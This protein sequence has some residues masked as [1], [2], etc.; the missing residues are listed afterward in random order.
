MEQDVAQVRRY[1]DANSQTEWERLEKHPY[2]FAITTRMLEQVIRPGDS[3]LDIGGG[4]GR[5]S[6][7]FAKMGCRVALLDLSSANTAL[8]QEKARA[9]NVEIQAVT[10]DARYAD[11][12][13]SGPFDHVL[14]MGPLYH[15]L[16]ERDRVMCVQS[17]LRLLKPGGTLSASFIQMIGVYIY[18]MRQDPAMLAEF[19]AT[20]QAERDCMQAAREGKSFGGEGFTMAYFYDPRE[21]EPFL[22][23][24]GLEKL[25][26][27]GQEGFLQPCMD[28]FLRQSQPVQELWTDLAFALCQREYLLGMSE[29]IMYVGRKPE[30]AFFA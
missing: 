23:Q 9:A 11:A 30:A 1:Y 21:I 2:E 29:H 27:F 10:G 12:L 5:Y 25:Y 4:P 8:A 24:F 18:Y 28:K 6:V 13:L 7:H 26:L 16:E 19:L 3:V 22:A 15:L 14:L 17:A 20:S